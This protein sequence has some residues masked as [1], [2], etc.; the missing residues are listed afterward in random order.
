MET[1]QSACSTGMFLGGSYSSHQSPIMI[2][3]LF[4]NRWMYVGIDMYK[5][6]S[7]CSKRVILRSSRKPVWISIGKGVSGAIT[8]LQYQRWSP[9]SHQEPHFSHLLGWC[10]Q[11]I[12]EEKWLLLFCLHNIMQILS[13]AEPLQKSHR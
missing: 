9:R 10:L 2:Q 6:H 12:K 4:P 11:L 13:L 1:A 3:T 5:N 7:C 8:Y